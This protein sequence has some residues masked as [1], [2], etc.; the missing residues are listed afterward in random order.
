MLTKLIYNIFHVCSHTKTDNSLH[1]YNKFIIN[2]LKYQ[3][4]FLLSLEKWLQPA[5]F[6][7]LASYL[8]RLI[9]IIH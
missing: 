6:Y 7:F 8:F 2:P 9:S 1:V 4:S 3:L 5:D